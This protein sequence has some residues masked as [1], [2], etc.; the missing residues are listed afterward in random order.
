MVRGTFRHPDRSQ[1]VVAY[2]FT[3]FLVLILATGAGLQIYNWTSVLPGLAHDD[4][5]TARS[6]VGVYEWIKYNTPAE[7]NVLWENDTALY[8]ATGRHSAAF[9]I[10]T[11]QYY[12]KGTDEDAALYRTIDQYAREHSLGYV[13]LPKVGMHRNDEILAS[14]AKNPGLRKVYEEAGAVLYRVE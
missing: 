3:G 4:R 1:R 10:P 14:A 5:E 11:R 8:L 6:F 7:T 12:A 9:L 13:M 2:G